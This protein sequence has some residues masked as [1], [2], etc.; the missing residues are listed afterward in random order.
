VDNIYAGGPIGLA[1]SN[2]GF[3]RMN[4]DIE[5]PISMGISFPNTSRAYDFS[6]A[7]LKLLPKAVR[8]VVMEVRQ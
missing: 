2:S 7:I 6:T 8:D 3:A 4:V 5:I 1:R